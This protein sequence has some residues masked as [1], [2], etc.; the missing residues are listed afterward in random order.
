MSDSYTETTSRSWFGRIK[1]SLVGTLF[2]LALFLG[3][4]VLLFWNEG[5]AVDTQKMLQ[6]GAGV[7]V[8]VNAGRVDPA[9]EGKLVHVSGR[10]K[11]SDQLED[12]IFEVKVNAIKLIRKVE[13]MQ[14]QERS[15][16]ETTK[17][18]GGGTETVTTYSYVKDWSERLIDSS[19]FKQ[20]KGHKN[21]ANM[22]MTSET[23]QAKNANLGAF[24]LSSGQIGG[25]NNDEP[26]A[27]K[28]DNKLKKKIAGKARLENG[29]MYLGSKKKN[30]VGDYRIQMRVV[31]P[32]DVSIIAGQ[33][34]NG[35]QPYKT[36]AGGSIQMLANSIKPAA[37][38]FE[39]AEAANTTT[40]WILRFVGLMVM[41][42]GLKMIVK[43]LSVLAD[44][45]PFFGNI[46]GGGTS[47]IAFL[48]A[49]ILS[50]LT[51]AVAWVFYRPLLSGGLVVAAIGI[52]LFTRSKAKSVGIPA[53]PDAVEPELAEETTDWGRS[54]K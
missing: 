48:V 47:L 25:I 9:N 35:F 14:W 7:V 45:V 1:D 40:T 33:F 20:S 51:I 24:R 12:P 49:L 36:A 3:A 5:R 6:E 52:F 4:F 13:M 28:K 29:V 41:F 26:L 32:G 19:A 18:L 11:T 8:S 16:S 22:L 39:A 15:K 17:K 43:I 53:T 30:K 10:V 44:V 38:M 23:W 34:G 31:Y 54:D 50:L 21:P 46:V 37:T 42:T 27:L 2:G